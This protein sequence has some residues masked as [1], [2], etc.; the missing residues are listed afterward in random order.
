L[1]SCGGT[2]RDSSG[3]VIWQDPCEPVQPV[4]DAIYSALQKYFPGQVVWGVEEHPL[5]HP[6]GSG[7]CGRVL[8]PSPDSDATRDAFYKGLTNIHQLTKEEEPARGP[9]RE[10]SSRRKKEE[11][12]GLEADDVGVGSSGSKVMGG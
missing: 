10:R 4:L 2:Q 6:L 1:I 7:C 8:E 9:R 12:E 11:S 3:V 5:G